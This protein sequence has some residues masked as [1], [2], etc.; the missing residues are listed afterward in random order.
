M[1]K[2]NNLKINNNHHALKKVLKKAR[3]NCSF[4]VVLYFISLGFFI[5]ALY[6]GLFLNEKDSIFTAHSLKQAMQLIVHKYLQFKDELVKHEFHTLFNEYYFKDIVLGFVFAIL[7]L[8]TLFKIFIRQF[9]IASKLNNIRVEIPIFRKIF[10]YSI[11][12]ILFCFIFPIFYLLF[13]FILAIYG[14]FC[15][16]HALSKIDNEKIQLQDKD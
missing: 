10:V 11:L 4:M 13:P 2:T 7:Y 5:A 14:I 9:K 16:N 12:S 8:I 1:Q 6:F 3:R 15:T